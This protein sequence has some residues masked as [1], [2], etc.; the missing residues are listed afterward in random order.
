MSPWSRRRSLAA[1]GALA[2]AGCASPSARGAPQ[3]AVAGGGFGGATLAR[4]LRL[5]SAGRVAV[6]LIDREPQALCCPMS[7]LVVVGQG[8]MA[9]LT[10]GY[11]GLTR[12]GVRVVQGEVVGVDAS[13][14]AVYLTDGSRLAGQ[15]LVLAPGVGFM[16]ETVPGLAAALTRGDAVQAW[17]A[18]PETLALRAQ[19]AALPGGG[20][21]LI[22]VPRAPYRCPPGPYE[23]ACLV[24]E[25]LQRHKPRAKLL[26]RDA[27]AEITSKKALFTQVFAQ[28]Y[29]GVL[30]Y[31]PN[32]ELREVAGHTAQFDF[33]AVKADVLNLIAP[34]RAGDLLHGAG[35][36]RVNGRWA[37]VDWRTLALRD[38]P[39]VHVLGDATLAAPGMPKSATMANQHAKVAAAAILAELDGGP[40]NPAPLLINTCYSFVAADA[41]A[42]VASVHQWDAAEATVKPVVGAGGVSPA[43]SAQEANLA[44][45]WF[46]SLRADSFAA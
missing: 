14:R 29:A 27:N 21:V 30:E 3:V 46:A 40:A 15:R 7:N 23:R 2:L 33:D 36:A 19:L 16:T 42:H 44:R 32:S 8:G 26:L 25:F 1:L 18:G 41:A 9:D 20:V 5:W 11:G 24:A 43:A 35:L 28:R 17:K 22:S 39:G 4:Y 12:L 38:A 34:Q 45:A 6:T 13:A 37:D 10:Q 31:H